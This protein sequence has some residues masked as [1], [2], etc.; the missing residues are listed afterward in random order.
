MILIRGG[1]VYD[2]KGNILENTDIL[3]EGSTIKDIAK[4]Y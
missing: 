2:G 3:I 1:K 4:I